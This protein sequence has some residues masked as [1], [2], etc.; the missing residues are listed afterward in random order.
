MADQGTDQQAQD[1]DQQQDGQQGA[2]DGAGS[3][4]DAPQ[5]PNPAEDFSSWLEA[6]DDA[7]KTGYEQNTA[8]LKSALDK[9]RDRAKETETELRDALK[10]LEGVEGA[11]E[12]VTE[13]ES[14]LDDAQKQR[15]AAE[16]ERDFIT[17]AVRE[18][19]TDPT[20]AWAA[21]Q[22]N[23]TLL[24]RRGL[25]DFGKLKEQ[26]PALFAKGS[27]PPPDGTPGTGG[28]TPPEGKPDMN[29]LIRGNV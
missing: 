16:R 6:Q 1:D 8:G 25:V 14:K 26:H 27:P 2:Q 15:E 19:V 13:L 11:Q 12:T 5:A 17:E 22:G 21:V 7:V 28:N 18:G 4:A 10:K 3:A 9:E 29:D 24:D 23:E 20:L